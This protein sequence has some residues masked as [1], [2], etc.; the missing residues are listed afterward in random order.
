MKNYK[1]NKRGLSHCHFLMFA[2]ITFSE[3]SYE[4]S[5]VDGLPTG[6]KITLHLKAGDAAEYGDEAKIK[7]VRI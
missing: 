4:V 7:D 5:E 1:K 6:T 3:N 2:V